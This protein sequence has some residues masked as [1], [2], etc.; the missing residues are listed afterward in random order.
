M[1]V[2]DATTALSSHASA[3]LR[4]RH[5]NQRFARAIHI[6][7]ETIDAH[8]ADECDYGAKYA[9]LIPD[10]GHTL[11]FDRL[12]RSLAEDLGLFALILSVPLRLMNYSD[13]LRFRIEGRMSTGRVQ[14]PPRLLWLPRQRLACSAY[15]H[16]CRL[17]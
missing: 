5:G 15:Q 14:T 13:H 1:C 17:F 4:R 6:R 11:G 9:E 16:S 3:S 12:E 7:P 2:S 10:A 8:D